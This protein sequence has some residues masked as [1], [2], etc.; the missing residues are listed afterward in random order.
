MTNGVRHG[1][2]QG[3]LNL[4]HDDGHLTCGVSDHGPGFPD[5]FFGGTEL[6]SPQT[7]GGRGLWLAQ[8]LTD[9]LLV[10]S[11]PVGATVT[12]TVCLPALAE[13]AAGRPAALRSWTATTGRPSHRTPPRR[14]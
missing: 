5:G 8:E 6:P 4:A 14:R 13:P 7:L 1:G 3:Q 11:G 9:T 12:V 10:T 2:G